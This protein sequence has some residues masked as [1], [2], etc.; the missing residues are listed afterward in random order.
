M[1]NIKIKIFV[2]GGMVSEVYS[3]SK[4][5]DVEIID[6]DCE[7]VGEGLGAITDPLEE[8]MNQVY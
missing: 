8:G 1:K 5:I 2:K 3:D 7:A 6:L 4:K